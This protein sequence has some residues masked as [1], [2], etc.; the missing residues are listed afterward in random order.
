MNS[1]GLIVILFLLISTVAFSQENRRDTLKYVSAPVT[2]LQ[3]VQNKIDDFEIYRQLNYMRLKIPP[4]ADSNTVW[5]WTSLVVS[6]S[7][8]PDNHPGESPTNWTEPLYEQFIETSKFNP[9]RYVLGMA[10]TAAVGYLAY[11][12]IKKYGL[13]K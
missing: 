13:F 6:N 12:H 1:N 9:V 5:M 4:T 11:Q 7:G 8:N 2:S 10:Q 3:S